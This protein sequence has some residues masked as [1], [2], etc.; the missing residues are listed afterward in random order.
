MACP[1]EVKTIPTNEQ[2]LDWDWV[3][4]TLMSN[5][6]VVYAN[7]AGI[8]VGMCIRLF[9][10]ERTI[11]FVCIHGLRESCSPRGTHRKKHGYH[12]VLHI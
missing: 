7:Y 1:I 8:P 2:E 12:L 3:R 10:Y 11:M 9:S 4:G 6:G 5:K